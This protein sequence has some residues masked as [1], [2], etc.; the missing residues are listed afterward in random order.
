MADH[1]YDDLIPD[2]EIETTVE[3]PVLDEIQREPVDSE[4]LHHIRGGELR[5][6]EL[7]ALMDERFGSFP[8]R[9]FDHV[10]VGPLSRMWLEKSD[11]DIDA[12]S[13]NEP[14]V[15]ALMLKHARVLES[16]PAL[17]RHLES[18]PMTAQRIGFDDTV[19]DQS[20]FWRAEQLLSPLEGQALR[21]AA[22]RSV[23]GAFRAGSP[24]PPAVAEEYD[25]DEEE[26]RKGNV[27]MDTRMWSLTQR[28]QDNL[29]KSMPHLGF[30]RA[31]NAQYDTSVFYALLAH[32][33]LERCYPE[34]GADVFGWTVEGDREVPGGANLYAQMKKFSR[35]DI[36]EK[37]TAATDELLDVARREEVL[38]GPVAL[39][40]D[41]TGIPWFGAQPT[42][43][44]IGEEASDNFAQGWQFVTLAVVSK[45]ARF[46]LG[47]LPIKYK[48]ELSGVTRRLL[49]HSCP[50][51]DA[52]RVYLDKEFHQ[53]AVIEALRSVGYDFLIQ[54]KRIGD[55]KQLLNK[56]TPGEIG[57]RMGVSVGDLTP[58]TNALVV[59]VPEEEIG[60]EEN[61]RRA[62]LTDMDVENRNLEGLYHQFRERW[63]IETLFWQLKDHY[64]PKTNSPDGRVRTFY[65]N[66]A[67]LFY[68]MHTLVNRVP[69]LHVPG[70]TGITGWE[71]LHAIREAPFAGDRL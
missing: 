8:E 35:E 10:V 50:R 61:K 64:L 20:T 63:S 44:T 52:K 45:R 41:V 31:A 21:E 15:S 34:T 24:I 28:V 65:L 33:A 58:P 12:L 27:G 38:E 66:T 6:R 2:F 67:L 32:L 9:S 70:D 5:I 13:I 46:A 19:P 53:E 68:N 56:T 39:S 22:M 69:S 40:I 37:F 60:S 48:R 62:Y 30:D 26:L 1:E 16:N 18:N 7:K 29:E 54:A 11:I 14:K 4:E 17:E 49:R 57:A 51:V 23:H 47:I 25:L 43:W 36:F 3:S 59:P 42:D 71:V 55:V